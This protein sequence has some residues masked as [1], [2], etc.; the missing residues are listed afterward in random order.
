MT[1]EIPDNTYN[2]RVIVGGELKKQSEATPECLV[3]QHLVK[4]LEKKLDNNHSREQIKKILDHVCDKVKDN[5]KDKCVSF[6]EKH[7]EQIIDLVMKGTQPKELC[8]ALGFCAFATRRATLELVMEEDSM[9]P[10]IEDLDIDE[11][12]SIDFIA[13]PARKHS[14]LRRLPL[15][16]QWLDRER[17]PPNVRANEGCILCEFVMTKLEADM[18]NKKTQDE[19]RKAVEN[20]CTVMPKSV[21][22]PCT[23]FIDNY[24]E[25]ILTLLATTPPAKICE[26]LKLCTPPKLEDEIHSAAMKEVS[27]DVLECAVC[28]GAVTV[29]DKLLEDPNFDRDLEKVVKSTCTIA[30][31]LYKR[32]CSELVESYGPS[33][34]NMLLV[35][36]NPQKV[37]EEISLCFANEVSSFVQIN[38]GE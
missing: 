34:I 37:C 6:M 27:N 14:P 30:P 5:L 8:I 2:G 26:Q 32:K 35:K 36:M 12:I 22:A 3:C 10:V 4:E 19:I 28:Q 25:L 33:I 24:T 9:M 20:I 7:E 11:A 16:N 17:Q 13:V 38:D 23:K 21:R 29:I 31:K 1:N 18:G 15:T